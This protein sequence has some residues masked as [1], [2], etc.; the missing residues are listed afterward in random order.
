MIRLI[1]ELPETVK[2][3]PTTTSS[4]A[5]TKEVIPVDKK[6][7]GESNL[8]KILRLGNLIIRLKEDTLKIMPLHLFAYVKIL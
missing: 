7:D 3:I 1:P 4:P 2:V 6:T 5:I 8:I